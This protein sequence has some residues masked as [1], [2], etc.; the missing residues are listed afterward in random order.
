M[1]QVRKL[2]LGCVFIAALAVGGVFLYQAQHRLDSPA[3]KPAEPAASL[4]VAYIGDDF[5]LPAVDNELPVYDK[6]TEAMR[7]EKGL[8]LSYGGKREYFYGERVAY[9]T[10]DDGPNRENTG[11]ILDILS[12]EGIHGTFFLTGQN[13]ERY[14]DVVKRI[15]QSGNAIGMH[16]YSHDYKKIYASPQAYMQEMAQ[17]EGLIYQA[18]G[19][20]PIISRAPGGTSGHFTKEY[21][22]ALSDHGYIE[23]GWN[24]L[25]GDAD[26]TGKTAAKEVANLKSQLQ[27]RPYLHSHLI[28]LMHDASGHEATVQALPEIIRLLRSQGYTFRVVTTAVPQ[29]W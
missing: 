20:C 10:F 13:V 22:Q 24:A 1:K 23:V 2:L 19:V 21:W 6:Y 29:P 26:G 9:L 14:P 27:A 16:S 11:R 5:S 8:P 12:Q 15:Y 28:I 17:T 25:T 3:E 18:I 4:Q 7:K